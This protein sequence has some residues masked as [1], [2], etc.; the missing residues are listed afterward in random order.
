MKNYG[1]NFWGG[2]GGGRGGWGELHGTFPIETLIA[3]SKLVD[4]R[5]TEPLHCELLV[6]T[7]QFQ[8]LI[9]NPPPLV[10]VKVAILSMAE[11]MHV[12]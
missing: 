12:M 5:D 4:I 7:I 9:M 10:G 3:G 1:L 11:D 2:Q 8:R 6:I